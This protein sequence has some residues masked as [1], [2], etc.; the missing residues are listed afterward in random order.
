[1]IEN[2]VV[3]KDGKIIA[4]ES[5]DDLMKSGYSISGTASK[6]DKYCEDQDVIG[7]DS[8]GGLKT[9]YIRGKIDGNISDGLEVSK[10]DLQKLFIKMTN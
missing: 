2:I 7:I 9:A 4:D 8:I 5:R 1:M 6:I 3:I 10:L